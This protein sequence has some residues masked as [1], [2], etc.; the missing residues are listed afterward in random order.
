MRWER[1]VGSHEQAADADVPASGPEFA[2]RAAG[3]KTQADRELKIEATIPAFSLIGP[4]RVV[5]LRY[6]H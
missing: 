5:A 2:D 1:I 6:R 3:E 4:G